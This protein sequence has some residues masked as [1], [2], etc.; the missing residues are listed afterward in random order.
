MNRKLQEKKSRGQTKKILLIA[1][2]IIAIFGIVN[3][4]NKTLFAIKKFINI[5]K[6]FLYGLVMGY[7]FL[8]PVKKLEKL[9]TRN[10]KTKYNKIVKIFSLILVYFTFFGL[11]YF[12]LSKLLPFLYNAAIDIL[13]NTPKYLDSLEE[14][15][16]NK[17][18]DNQLLSSFK[19]EN[20]FKNIR[21]LDVPK[22]LIKYLKG[23]NIQ[24]GV[25]AIFNAAGV[26]IKIF[27]AIV[28]SFNIILYNENLS[29]E[30]KFMA[31]G[32]L[33][34]EKANRI[35]KIIKTI[36]EVFINFI[37]GQFID[38]VIV[39]IIF[40]IVFLILKIQYAVALGILIGIGNLIPYVG[41]FLSILITVIVTC[42]TGGIGKGALILA[43][44]VGIQQIDAQIIN[45]AIIGEKLDL[46]PPIIILTILIGGAYFGS[47]VVFLAAPILA[48]I[49][50]ILIEY[51]ENKKI[52]NKVDKIKKMRK[53]LKLNKNPKYKKS[54]KL[55]Y[56]LNYSEQKSRKKK[57]R[58]P[59][60]K[61]EKHESRI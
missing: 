3:N 18:H 5:I 16:I 22:I 47:I 25:N 30:M 21:S 60:I 51:I 10:K 2:L 54:Y 15:L 4:L 7:L 58:K 31:R 35:K 50:S 59:K 11:L 40:S 37:Y 48:V 13:E 28:V 39:G 34:N 6:P 61:K 23:F 20:I 43:V 44:S 17:S 8:F 38:S 9:I 52:K 41:S 12:F 29:K 14:F 49:K 32:I 1:F 33:G 27:I 57:I 36:N 56:K 26:I 19:I 53:T 42:F 24:N 45:P 46:D 55:D